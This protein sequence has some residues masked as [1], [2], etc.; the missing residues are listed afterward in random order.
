MSPRPGRDVADDGPAARQEYGTATDI[1]TAAFAEGPRSWGN[2]RAIGREIR[3]DEA[4]VTIAGRQVL[5][6]NVEQH[7]RYEAHMV[8]EDSRWKWD[9]S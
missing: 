3:G 7:A 1:D 6:G 4:V 5:E 8:R 2:Y 9:L